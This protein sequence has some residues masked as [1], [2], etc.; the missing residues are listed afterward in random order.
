MATEKPTKTRKK[1]KLKDGPSARQKLAIYL[2][3]TVVLLQAAVLL[4]F[5]V[6]R[7]EEPP[8]AII[9]K[10]LHE[11]AWARNNI[12]MFYPLIAVLIAGP[13]L[14]SL[15]WVIAGWHRIVLAASWIGFII[16]TL[17]FFGR[18][19]LVMLRILSWYYT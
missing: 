15:A 11:R 8:N 14:T 18:M 3:W 5:Y 19:V 10:E 7:G 1:K 9:L 4:T 17:S 2:T 13:I 12:E 16:M 6:K